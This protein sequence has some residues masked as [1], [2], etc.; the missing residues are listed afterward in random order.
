MA[1]NVSYIHMIHPHNLLLYQNCTHDKFN[2][3]IQKV[4][5]ASS[6]IC[7]ICFDNWTNNILPVC[8]YYVFMLL[9]ESKVMSTTGCRL[10]MLGIGN[11]II[12]K[13]FIDYLCGENMARYCYLFS[14]VD[15]TGGLIECLG[16]HN[17]YSSVLQRTEKGYESF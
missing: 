15:V 5:C 1:E 10:Y 2:S 13:I 16:F 12:I 9:L 3:K 7:F 17:C 14:H 4:S 8:Y 11:T 6:T